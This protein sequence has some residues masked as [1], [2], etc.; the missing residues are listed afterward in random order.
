MMASD[1]E[2]IK[3]RWCHAE[4]YDLVDRTI[5]V[6]ARGRKTIKVIVAPLPATFT[7]YNIR[8][9]DAVVAFIE[10]APTPEGMHEFC[11]A[12]GIPYGVQPGAVVAANTP[13]FV[14]VDQM[15]GD[16][17]EMR[18]A[19]KRYKAHPPDPTRIIQR[20]N[21]VSERNGV[22]HPGVGTIVRPMLRRMPD[23]SVRMSFELP[24][25]MEAMWFDL[26]CQA[27]S[28]ARLLSCERCGKPFFVGHGTGRR[29]TAM[30]CSQTCNS[31]VYLARKREGQNATTRR[32]P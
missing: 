1:A 12:Y 8:A 16:H 22:P 26:A 32:R 11:Q 5:N 20:T 10:T 4:R 29:S 21:G 31:A 25:L 19:V 9:Q 7:D 18:Q 2:T 23:K 3:F 6:G 13:T 30:Y 24:D 27:C 28:G 14:P 17:L 15:L